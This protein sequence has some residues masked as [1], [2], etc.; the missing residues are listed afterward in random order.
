M[1]GAGSVLHRQHPVWLFDLDDT[2]HDANGASMTELREAM[3][4][5]IQ[6]ELNLSAE[7][8][9][10][11]RRRYW[12]RYG[13]TLLGLVRHHNVKAAHFL[14]HTHQLPGLEERIRSHAHDLAA[15]ARLP[16]RK[17]IL[18]NAPAAYARRVLGVLGIEGWFDGVM[19]IED[20]HMFGSL[21]PKPDA[22]M[23]R[24]VAA[25]LRVHPA[26]C[27]LV[28]DSAGNLKGAR[29][30][31]MH[32]VWL[33][34]WLPAGASRT[35]A[36]RCPAYVDQRVRTLLELERR[37]TLQQPLLRGTTTA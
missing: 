7:E 37:V 10:A 30:A 21:R 18:T 36:R 24:R 19:S 16:G 5:Y 6:R 12:L 14:H 1:R 32:T 34:R 29:R 11:L 9:N 20:M 27:V 31:G 23:L 8:S 26:R 17:Y 15:L 13:A 33:R 2:L 28:E 3:G 22:R 25:R 4:Q 35:A